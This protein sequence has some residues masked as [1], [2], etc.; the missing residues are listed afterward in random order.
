MASGP[1]IVQ[2]FEQYLKTKSSEPWWQYFRSGADSEQTLADNALAFQRYR[3]RPRYL[4][5]VSQRDLSISLL[6]HR[7]QLP[8]GVCPSSSHGM[9]HP[10]AEIATAKGVASVGSAMGLSMWSNKPL[11]DIAAAVAPETPLFQQLNVFCDRTSMDRLT[12]HAEW[13]VKRTE[14]AGFKGIVLTVDQPVTGNGVERR[15]TGP[16]VE[17]LDLT[18]PQFVVPGGSYLDSED[19]M[20]LDPSLTW[21]DLEWLRD[22]TSLPIVLKGILTAEDASEAVKRGVSAI[23]VSNHGGRQLDGAPATIDALP[24]VVNAVRGSNVEVYL[25]GGVRKGTD[26]LKALALGARAVFIGR[27]ALWGLAYDGE[28]GVR[29]VLE[30]L[31]EELS[32]AMALTGCSS[33]ADIT[34]DLIKMPSQ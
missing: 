7:L 24:E 22:L 1:I 23:W 26:V 18:F 11:E 19:R 8:I 28:A 3:L 15:R 13:L 4:R 16:A 31:R 27:P 6:G 14:R 10:E 9:V 29:K 5:D 32:R 20:T 33:I 25:D 12:S 17:P 2:D 34:P 30:I 21:D